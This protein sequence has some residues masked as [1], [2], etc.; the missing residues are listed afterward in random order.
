MKNILIFGASTVHGIGGVYGGWAD[1]VKQSFHSELYG[2]SEVP[3]EDCDVYELGVPGA[4]LPDLLERFKDELKVRVGDSR[5][6]DIHIVFSA[7]LNDSRLH[8]DSSR[9]LYSPDDFA[10]SVHAF[11]HLAK[12]YTPHIL[13]VGITPIHEEKVNGGRPDSPYVLL[14]DSVRTFE[15]AFE[16][17][18]EAEGIVFVPLCKNVPPDWEQN[19]LFADGLHPNDRGHEWIRSR[20]EPVLRE[21][22]GLRA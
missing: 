7:G 9:H 1:K 22:V 11:I 12:A 21:Q 10:A 18:C 16:R 4:T 6:E 13:G 14:N 17:T 19:Y 8:R 5:P 3:A 15:E 2:G 20:V